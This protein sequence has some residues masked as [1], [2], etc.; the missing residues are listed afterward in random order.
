M[1]EPNNQK[2]AGMPLDDDSR[3]TLAA[4]VLEHFPGSGCLEEAI[5]NLIA[6]LM[7]L[8]Q[9]QSLSPYAVI[10][11][12]ISLYEDGGPAYPDRII[13]G[14]GWPI[15][16]KPHGQAVALEN[17]NAKTPTLIILKNPGLED[18]PEAEGITYR[19]VLERCSQ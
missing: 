17:N 16:S 9:E 13:L 6:G 14:E 11:G 5:V 19:L 18:G 12:G 1:T 3:S 2:K 15:F 8:A 10:N 7:H 4:R